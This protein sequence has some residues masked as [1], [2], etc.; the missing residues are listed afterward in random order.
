LAL[1]LLQVTDIF[2]K[3]GGLYA[4]FAVCL[5]V[6]HGYQTRVGVITAGEFGVSQVRGVELMYVCTWWCAGGGGIVQGW[7]GTRRLRHWAYGL[8]DSAWVSQEGIQHTLERGR[9]H[10]V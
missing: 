9:V 6:D 5:L 4:R 7:R 10:T 8:L 1:A 2:K 3:E